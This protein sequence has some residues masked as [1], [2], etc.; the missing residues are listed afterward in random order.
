MMGAVSARRERTTEIFRSAAEM[1]S[2][3]K[4]LNI[5]LQTDRLSVIDAAPAVARLRALAD[6]SHVSEGE[7]DGRYI[8]VSFEVDDIAVLWAAVQKQLQADTA[9]AAATIVV[10]QGQHGWDDYLLLH[11]FDPSEPLETIFS[12]RA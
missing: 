5:Q 4:A 9:L 10:C 6:G 12:P 11:H 3:M 2:R 7:D 8:N 1:G